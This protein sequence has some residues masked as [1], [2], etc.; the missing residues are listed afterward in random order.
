MSEHSSTK[1]SNSLTIKWLS[2]TALALAAADI[3]LVAYFFITR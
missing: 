2:V 1:Y 3:A